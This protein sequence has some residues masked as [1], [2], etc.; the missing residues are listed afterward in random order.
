MRPELDQL[1]KRL[2]MVQ[3]ESIISLHVNVFL[4]GRYRDIDTFENELRISKP[5]STTQFY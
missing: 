2:S 3:A 5:L 1:V 4:I